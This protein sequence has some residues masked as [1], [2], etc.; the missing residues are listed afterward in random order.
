M[1]TRGFIPRAR[2]RGHA[3]TLRARALYGL[4]DPGSMYWDPRSQGPG[5]QIP[6][7]QG[8]GPS[9]GPGSLGPG[10]RGQGPW[11]LAGA[12]SGAHI[13]GEPHSNRAPGPRALAPARALPGPSQGPGWGPILGLVLR[14]K[15][16]VG[17]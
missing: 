5:A 12:C 6:G 13:R 16:T 8:P 2:A 10:A 7:S 11:A 9:Q 15:S 1:N 14:A 4:A 3:R 17:Q